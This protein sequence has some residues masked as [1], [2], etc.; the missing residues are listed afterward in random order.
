MSASVCGW[1]IVARCGGPP[2]RASTQKLSHISPQS[3]NPSARYL[4]GAAAIGARLSSSLLAIYASLALLTLK[5]SFLLCVEYQPAGCMRAQHRRWGL[6]TRFPTPISQ[7]LRDRLLALRA[8]FAQVALDRQVR[9]ARRVIPVQNA[10][11][12]LLVE[13]LTIVC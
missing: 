7:A 2:S 1:S 9:R 4:I 8:Q 13:W 5:S 6:G 10:K 11:R 12:R 3:T